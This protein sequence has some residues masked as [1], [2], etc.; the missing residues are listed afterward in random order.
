MKRLGLSSVLLLVVL[1][2][3]CGLGFAED[4]PVFPPVGFAGLA[5]FA[6]D[7]RAFGP[8]P[9]EQRPFM[10]PE[11]HHAMNR[12]LFGLDGLTIGNRVTQAENEETCIRQKEVMPDGLDAGVS[13]E[14][15]RRYREESD[16]CQTMP[17]VWWW[18]PR[19]T[20]M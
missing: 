15:V 7:G 4:D 6:D 3:L 11:Y 5:D 14:W 20:R 17:L 1:Y 12:R 18:M 9:G 2:G 10:S 8:F 19:G 16:G 13:R